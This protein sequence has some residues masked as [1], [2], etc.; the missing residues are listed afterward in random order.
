MEIT[1][2]FSLF[3]ST[4]VLIQEAESQNGVGGVGRG[5]WSSLCSSGA[6]RDQ[7]GWLFNVPKVEN[8]TTLCILGSL[9][10]FSLFSSALKSSQLFS[11]AQG[12]P[13]PCLGGGAGHAGI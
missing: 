12:D 1:P 9:V 6:A 7:A 13:I 8:S 5:L 4:L 11:S 3:P 2:C 10:V